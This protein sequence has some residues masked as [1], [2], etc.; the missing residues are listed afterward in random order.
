M[1]RIAC[2]PSRYASQRLPGKALI[3]IAGKPLILHVVERAANIT[4]LDEVIVL[5]DDD[6]ILKT[7]EQAGFSAAMTHPHCRNGTERII[8]YLQG[9]PEIEQVVN[10]QG[11]ELFLR[12]SH[13]QALLENFDRLAKPHMGTL[14]YRSSDATLINSPSSVKI[15]TDCFSRAL[16]FSRAPIP[17]SQ[18]GHAAHTALL[19][20]AVYIY[21]QRTLLDFAELTPSDLELCESLE[22]LR[23]LSYGIPIHITTVAEEHH[24]SIDTPEDLALARRWFSDAG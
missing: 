12:A 24:L 8:D 3:E 21:T 14:A 10:I 9:R 22:Q 5:T 18:Q 19:H 15:V 6:R 11:D 13:V 20:M 7:V 1:K 17:V 4:E 2:I 23:L 16:Y